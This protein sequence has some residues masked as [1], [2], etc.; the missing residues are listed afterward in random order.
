LNIPYSC[1]NSDVD[2]DDDAAKLSSVGASSDD[3]AAAAASAAASTV[4]SCMARL[5][6]MSEDSVPTA[7]PGSGGAK[8]RCAVTAAAA[9]DVDGALATSSSRLLQCVKMRIDRIVRLAC[10]ECI[11]D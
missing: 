1:S 7:A 8:A 4:T 3:D 9:A 10:A 2:D 11:E 5:M 6:Y